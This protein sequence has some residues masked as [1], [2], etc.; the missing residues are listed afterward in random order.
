MQFTFPFSITW[1]PPYCVYVYH[2]TKQSQ[3]HPELLVGPYQ[4]FCHPHL[5]SPKS[6]SLVQSQARTV[7][8]VVGREMFPTRPEKVPHPGQLNCQLR[9][10]LDHENHAKLACISA[11]NCYCSVGLCRVQWFVVFSPHRKKILVIPCFCILHIALP[12][13]TQHQMHVWMHGGILLNTKPIS[14]MHVWVH[15]HGGVLL[16]SKPI[17]LCHVN[18][19]GLCR[20]P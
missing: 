6:V 17:S 5:F 15:A 13:A 7:T 4:A 14:Q 1:D 19:V 18:V 10:K 9:F 3:S 12:P 2:V 20:R 8:D 16:I 11:S